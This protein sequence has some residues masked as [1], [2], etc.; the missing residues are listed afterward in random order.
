MEAQTDLPLDQPQVPEISPED[1]LAKAAGLSIEP[2]RPR[3]ERG[4]Y[5]PKQEEQAKPEEAK[6]EAEPAPEEQKPEAPE[7]EIKWEAI[8]DLKVKVPMKNGDKEWV[9]EKTFEDLRNERMMHA[10]YMARRREF[11]EQAKTQESKI[12]ETVEKER[13]QFLGALNV[14]QQ[15]VMR[16][17]DQEL[18]N[19]DWAK[20]AQEE[21]AKYVQLQ[22]R[23][24]MLGT[25][26][27]HIASEQEKVQKQQA[28]ERQKFIDQ[29][30]AESRTK[31]KEAIPSWND[32]LY[33]SLLRRG[34]DTY[35]FKPDEVGQWWDHR[36]MR[37]LHDA[38]QWQLHKEQKPTVEKKVVDIPPVLKSGP[39][40]VKVNP[41]VQQFQQA[42]QRLA[43]NGKDIDAAA[44]VMS[45]FVN[46]GRT[47]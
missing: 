28:E 22:A 11:D 6:P 34:V 27:Q 17:A 10:D 12:R 8:K 31:L 24:Q 19:V 45:A 40:K 39:Q 4:R 26:L 42:K 44:A 18:A 14:L 13:N 23:A 2:D 16:V 1:R 20:L 15:S 29:A 21:P 46:Q 25:T 38:H 9:E 3:D 35:G 5:V 7:D 43:A 32:D 37:V 36:V 41:Q 47:S 33:Q 30:A